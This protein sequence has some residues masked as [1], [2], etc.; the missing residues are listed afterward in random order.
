MTT[1]RTAD[2]LAALRERLAGLRSKGKADIAVCDGPGC[3][4]AGGREVGTALH[5]AIENG[6]LSHRVDLRLTGCLGLCECGPVV[7][8][9]PQGV[10]Y[11]QVSPDDA[12]D[13]LSSVVTTGEPVERLLYVDTTS[14]QRVRCRND[15]PFYR[16]QEP[17]VLASLANV[18]PEEIEDYIAIGGYAALAKSLA[19][20]APG[21]VIEE[22]K[23][24]QLRGRGGAGF[25]TGSKWE[26]CRQADGDRKYVICNADEGDPGA[27]MD[28]AVLEGNPHS[29]IEG[30]L[31]GAFAI[32]ATDGIIYVRAEYPIAVKNAKHAVDQARRYG[33]VGRN[34]LGSTFSFD[35]SI[36]TGAGAFVCGEETALIASLENRIGE[37]RPRPPFPAQQG[38]WGK[39]TNIN[40]VETWANVP[41]IISRGA[42]WFASVGSE[43]SKGTKIFSLVGEVRNTGLVEVPMGTTLRQVIFDVGGGSLP[44]R[45]IKAV[46]SGGPSGGCIPERLF[47]LPI[48]YES[49]A[50]AGSIMG[51]GGLIVMDNRTCV[52]DVVRYFFSFLEEESC[53]K[54]AP[55]REGIPRMLSILTDICEGR[56]KEGDLELLDKL[57]RMVKN[58]SLCG[59]GQTAPNPLLSSLRYF[60]D[61]YEAHIL[62]HRCPA[63]VCLALIHFE[64]DP[65]KCKGCGLC[66]KECP[67]DAISG[68]RKEPHQIDTAKCVKCGLCEEVCPDAAVMRV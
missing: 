20:M 2:D 62:D 24:A 30:M 38:L 17:R 10:F 9:R 53:G 36:A 16:N 31:I 51:S 41:L 68:E 13:I 32:G 40:N 59:L 65:D 28:R 56:C 8:I 48:D 54:C 45:T 34:I 66:Q 29:V 60:R 63:G 39:P 7:L 19:Q 37:P 64:I 50:Q 27:Y 4:A 33:L 35:L 14:G 1:V 52:V 49:L 25:P 57:G 5:E 44:D 6:G 21:E 11:Q 42:D 55:C 67:Q 15:I 61:E 23:R 58:A 12:E 47:D 3:H 46:Q 26:F 43:K 18:R 22:V